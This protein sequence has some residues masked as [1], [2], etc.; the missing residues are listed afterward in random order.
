MGREVLAAARP[1]A[2][3][4]AERD[5]RSPRELALTGVERRR[6][7][8]DKVVYGLRWGADAASRGSV[9]L[10]DRLSAHAL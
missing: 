2:R 3:P 8:S 4:P 1:V 7:M 9:P 6:L 5:E 10:V